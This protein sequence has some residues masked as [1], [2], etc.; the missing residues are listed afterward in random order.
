MTDAEQSQVPHPHGLLG[1]LAEDDQ[2]TSNAIRLFRGPAVTAVSA[3]SV[4]VLSLYLMPPVVSA[5]LV[6]AVSTAVAGK[7]WQSWRRR[8]LRRR[9]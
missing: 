1:Y 9:N 5:S 2:R 4:L 3:L 8:R 7:G 6:G